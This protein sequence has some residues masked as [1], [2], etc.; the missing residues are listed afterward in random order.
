[1]RSRPQVS[2]PSPKERATIGQLMSYS[3]VSPSSDDIDDARPTDSQR[4]HLLMTSELQREG[5]RGSSYE[6]RMLQICCERKTNPKILQTSHVNGLGGPFL[7]PL[8]AKSERHGRRCRLAFKKTARIHLSRG[9]ANREVR[10]RSAMITLLP[11]RNCF[12]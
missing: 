5:E 7:F 4:G 12:C 8:S 3:P 10:S 6:Q 2:P 11:S 1:M 9:R